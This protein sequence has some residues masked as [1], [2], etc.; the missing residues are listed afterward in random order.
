M[1][2]FPFFV[3]YPFCEYNGPVLER[4]KETSLIPQMPS[5]YFS[6]QTQLLSFYQIHSIIQ[7]PLPK[8]HEVMAFFL[9][10]K[11]GEFAILGR[12]WST[13][14]M[15][16]SKIHSQLWGDDSKTARRGLTWPDPVPF[17]LILQLKNIQEFLEANIKIKR[18]K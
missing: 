4:E 9:S 15:G 11:A 1:I 10:Q 2:D 6:R 18:S 7:H 8:S 12:T 16:M 14:Y 13:G 3:D 17:Y 5:V